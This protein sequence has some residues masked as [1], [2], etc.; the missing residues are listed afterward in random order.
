MY[1]Y[2][3]KSDGGKIV[4][5]E[6]LAKNCRWKTHKETWDPTPFPQFECCLKSFETPAITIDKLLLRPDREKE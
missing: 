4:I 6:F 3:K 1:K 2:L 5:T